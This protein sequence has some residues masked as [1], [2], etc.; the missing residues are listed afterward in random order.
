[1]CEDSPAVGTERVVALSVSL[2]GDFSDS[3]DSA[4]YR[5]Y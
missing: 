2:T 3:L 4:S 1:M 5:Y